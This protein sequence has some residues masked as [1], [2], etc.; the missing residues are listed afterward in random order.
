VS[1]KIQVVLDEEMAARFKRQAS[2]EAKSLSGWLRD[3]GTKVL[4]EA[5]AQRRLSN[6]KNLTDFFAKINRSRKGREPDWEEHKV[7]IAEGHLSVKAR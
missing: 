3:A 4:A 1:Q 2:K 7:L 5:N 6:V